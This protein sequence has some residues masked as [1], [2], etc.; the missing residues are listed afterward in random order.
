MNTDTRNCQIKVLKAYLVNC[1]NLQYLFM[2]RAWVTYGKG[3]VTPQG[4]HTDSLFSLYVFQLVHFRSCNKY[5]YY[6]D[7]YKY[8]IK[9]R[10]FPK[11]IHSPKVRDLIAPIFCPRITPDF[12]KKSCLKDIHYTV[13]DVVQI[14]SWK[15]N[16]VSPGKFRE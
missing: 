5:I 10:T 11:N 4:W 2:K 15:I 13:V 8:F 14:K 7:K 3:Y 12:I 1:C 16:L 9:N 6:I